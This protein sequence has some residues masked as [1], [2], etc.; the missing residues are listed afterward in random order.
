MCNLY[1]MT[2]NHAEVANWFKAMDEIG[3]ANLPG[4][5]YP[6][7]PGVVIADGKA[8]SMVW[9]FPLVL[10][11]KKTGQP[12]KPK[13]VN[14]ARTD[15]LGSYMWRFSF[16]ERRCLIPLTAWAEAEGAKGSMTRT[17]LSMPDEPLF[18]A[19]GIWRNTDEWGAAYSMVMTDAMGD[20]AQVHSRMPVIL[21]PDSYLQWTDG[22]PSEAKRLAVAYEG[23]LVIDRTDERWAR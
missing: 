13:P 17:W 14:N 8:K 11:S 1:R 18:A 3:G 21:T 4:E 16:E 5:V 6:G 12:L 15:K 10:K 9:G 19:A 22:T 2:K 20:A 7:S 23:P